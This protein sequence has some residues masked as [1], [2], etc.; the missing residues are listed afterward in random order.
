MGGRPFLIRI[1]IAG[2]SCLLLL[3]A[4]TPTTHAADLRLSL[5]HF[6]VD[7]TP[8]IGDGPCVGCMPKVDSIEHPLELRGV[9]LRSGDDTYV[10]AAIDFCGICNTSDEVLREAMARGAETTRERVALQSLH[11]HSAP[12]LDADAVRLLHGEKSA[13]F[14]QHLRFTNDIASRTA[15][16]IEKSLADLQPVSRVVGTKALV[17]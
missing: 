4:T 15:K 12:I 16:A 8:P 1:L 10:I 7:V 6:R 5:G 3:L 17:E 9:V 13:Q 14:A 11:Q 2:I